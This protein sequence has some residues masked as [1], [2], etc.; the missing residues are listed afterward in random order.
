MSLVVQKGRLTGT[1]HACEWQLKT[2]EYRHPF[3]GPFLYLVPILV[4]AKEYRH[5]EEAVPT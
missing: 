1:T 3:P 2:H 5:S 4:T